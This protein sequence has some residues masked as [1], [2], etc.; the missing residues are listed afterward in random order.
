MCVCVCVCMRPHCTCTYRIASI[1][2]TTFVILPV[3]SSCPLVFQMCACAIFNHPYVWPC[4]CC[5]HV[6]VANDVYPLS[7]LFSNIL[8]NLYFVNVCF[9]ISQSPIHKGSQTKRITIPP[10]LVAILKR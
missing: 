8:Y 5:H 6:C 10:I 1:S 7:Q 3:T 2:S 4:S 9:G